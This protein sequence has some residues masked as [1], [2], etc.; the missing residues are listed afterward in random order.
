MSESSSTFFDPRIASGASPVSETAPAGSEPRSSIEF[1]ELEAEVRKLETDGPLAVNWREVARLSTVVLETRGKD[2]LVGAWLAHALCRE[3]RFQGLAVGLGVLREM[4]AS[5]WDKMQPPAARERARVG[6]LEWLVGRTAPLCEGEASEGDWPAVLYAYDALT[7]IDTLAGE[8]LRKEQIALGDLVRALRP[9]RDTARRALAE[10]E[11]KRKE[12]ETEAAARAEQEAQAATRAAE[13][14]A[15]VSVPAATQAPVSAAA[16]TPAPPSALDLSTIDALPETLRSLSAELIGNSTADARAHLLSR[17]ASW[18]R[19][20]QLP[21]NEGGRTGAMPPVEEA[22]AIQAQRQAGQNQEALKALNELVWTAPFWFEGHRLT[23]EVLKS[24]GPDHADAGAAVGGAM[25]M[26]F[27][28]FPE[29]MNFSFGDGRPFVDPPTRDWI[30]ENGGSGG[31]ASGGADGLD[32]ALGEARAL[33]GAGKAPEA[34]DLLASLTRGEIGG[35][36]RVLRQIAQA[37]FCLDVG[38]ITAA[39]PLLDHLESLLKAHDLENWEPQLAAQVAELR[40]RALTHA[41]AARLVAEDRRRISLDETRQRLVR[42][43]LAT[44]ARLFR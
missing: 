35:R 21:P 39:L 10:A 13:A 44:A 4:I 8:K 12:I 33:I 6:A 36:N 27:R 41:D 9:H 38:L 26:L 42:L 30:E 7:E 22:A 17:V 40:F 34:I 29:L 37:R 28:R 31:A 16:P 15:P 25:N 1:E 2:L 5:H 43:D 14:P 18:W 24:M 20:R 3:E 11:Q 19:I 32:R 23:A